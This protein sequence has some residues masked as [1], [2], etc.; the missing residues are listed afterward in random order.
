[1]QGDGE[2]G[3]G[4]WIA[5]GERGQREGGGDGLVELACVSQGANEAVVRFGVGRIC[6]DGGAKGCSS[7]G[8]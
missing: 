7:F 4:E 2:R 8:G 1:L 5:R 3:V 6:G